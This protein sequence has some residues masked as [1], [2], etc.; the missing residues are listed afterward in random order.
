[1]D[2][3]KI[4]KECVE[5]MFEIAEVNL[6]Y[7]DVLGI[8][9]AWYD[10][11]TWT[12]EKQGEWRQWCIKHIKKKMRCSKKRAESEAGWLL[13]NIGFKVENKNKES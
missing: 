13:L 1:M 4:V 6:K 11:H 3:D 12:D 10:D 8:E 9:H 7:E 2:K 5:K